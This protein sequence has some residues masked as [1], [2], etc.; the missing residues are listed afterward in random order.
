MLRTLLIICCISLMSDVIAQRTLASPK[1]DETEVNRSK[2]EQE[3]TGKRK[4]KVKQKGKFKANWALPYPNPYRAAIYSFILPGAGQIYNKRYWK[5]PLVWGGFAA[6]IYSVN[7]NKENYDCFNLAYGASVRNLPHKYE[8]F[9]PSSDALR[10]QRNSF[11]KNLQ[12]TYIGFVALYA[13]TALDA[14]VDAHLKNFDI[15]DDLSLQLTLANHGTT[16]Q[17]VPAP[18]IGI[19]LTFRD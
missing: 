11:N 8:D 4:K 17:P 12:L 9:N 13:L 6:L 16:T 14:Y 10:N 18:G 2:S 3:D 15:S 1:A 19:R 7:Y 5:V